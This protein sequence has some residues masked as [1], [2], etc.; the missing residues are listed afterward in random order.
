MNFGKIRELLFKYGL[1]DTVP[2]SVVPPPNT[3]TDRGL[4]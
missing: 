4:A 2:D 3:S 1:A